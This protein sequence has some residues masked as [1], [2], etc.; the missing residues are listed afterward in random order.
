MKNPIIKVILLLTVFVVL[1]SISGG[2]FVKAQEQNGL[3]EETNQPAG[4]IPVK[5]PG[6]ASETVGSPIEAPGS[7]INRPT[8]DLPDKAASLNSSTVSP[9]A[10]EPAAPGADVMTP[11]ISNASWKWFT[12]A[13]AVFIPWSNTMQ[14]TYGGA[15]CLQPAAG[16][17]WRASVN[18]PDGSYLKEVYFGFY[19][20]NA[21]T[22]STAYLYRYPYTGSAVPVAQ[23]NSVAGGATTNGFQYEGVLI[24]GTEI[25]NNLNN[26]Y[27]FSWSGS[28]TQQLCY[29]QVGY[30]PPSI[31]GLA[32]PAISKQP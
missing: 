10:A 6:Q 31:F 12:T 9:A 17:Y 26:A 27:V 19:N 32:L 18:L 14:W 21:S 15:G 28:G 16:G 20:T 5:A 1:V 7:E 22:V 11:G 30:I 24:S 3:G 4:A 23:V 13:G 25:V 8:T 29:L 2:A